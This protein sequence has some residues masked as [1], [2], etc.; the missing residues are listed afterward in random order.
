MAKTPYDTDLNRRAAN[1]QPL[2]P[3]TLL[4]RAAAVFPDH[5]AIIHGG[6]R[7]TTQPLRAHGAG[8]SWRSWHRARRY[9][10]GDAP[11]RPM[12]GLTTGSR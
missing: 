2:T 7:S 11:V 8:I 12:L 5:T 4:E 10:V 3:L 6:Q 1:F 9:G